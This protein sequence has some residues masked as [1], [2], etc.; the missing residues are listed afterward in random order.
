MSCHYNSGDIH[1]TIQG[2]IWVLGQ[3]RNER[4]GITDIMKDG[5]ESSGV[6]DRGHDFV[7]HLPRMEDTWVELDPFDDL[8]L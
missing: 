3:D 5:Y 2:Q 6:G 8:V 1:R 4:R 7:D